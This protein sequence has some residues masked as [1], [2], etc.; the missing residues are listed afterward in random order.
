MPLQLLLYEYVDEMLA[1]RAPHREA[2]L[3]ALEAER[4]AGHVVIA[5]AYGDPPAG[6]VFVFN[7]VDADQVRAFA[8]ADPYV[9]AGLVRSWRVEPYNLVVLEAPR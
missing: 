1:R 5:G 6:A 8:E 9:Q 2:H 7:G 4:E 3:A